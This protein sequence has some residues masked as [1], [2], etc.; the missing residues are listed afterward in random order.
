MKKK[1]D[2]RLLVIFIQAS[3]AMLGSLYYSN[4]GDPVANFQAGE[5]FVVANGFDPCRLCWWARILMYPIVLISGLALYFKD[6]KALR[7]IIA[8]SIPG[9]GLEI[10]HYMLQKFDLVTSQAC[11]MANPCEALKVDYFG[12]ITI[13]FLCLT[14]FVVIL[15]AAT[16]KKES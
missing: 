9:V 15:L 16:W 6:T 7:Y 4:F 10:Y 12:F 3:L 8:L 14:A 2:K 5:L 11:T 1:I 13:P